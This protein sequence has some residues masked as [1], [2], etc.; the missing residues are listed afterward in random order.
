M[1][2]YKDYIYEVYKEKSISK[3]A[4]NL[5]VSQPSLSTRIIKIEKELGMP[6][7]DRSTSPLGLTEF[8]KIYIKAIEDIQEI[9]KRIQHTIEDL[10]MLHVGELTLGASN[11]FAA[12]ALPPIIAAFKKN[13][14]DVKIN[15]IEENTDTLEVLLNTNKVDMV[16]DNKQYDSDAYDRTLYTE[17]R[18]LL[19]VPKIFRECEQVKEFALNAACIQS[20][21][22]RDSTWPA[23]PLSVFQS[24]PFI[25]LT[26]NNDTRTRGNQI[27][28]EAGIQPNIVLEVHQQS[29]AY[30]IA[31]TMMGATFI[32]DS[33]VEKMPVHEHL[34]YYKIDSAA[35][36]RSVYF[37]YKK[38]KYKTRVMQEF[39]KF[40]RKK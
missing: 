6:I 11:I 29:T 3:A 19:A 2:R 15:L 25:M 27:C 38:N 24:V 34:A 9:E 1:F 37:Y 40:I 26:P 31:S 30:M 32:S 10:T 21:E 20:K 17:E 8:G 18:V 12:Y 35:A 7:F 33:I 22:Y 16:I 39:I 4:A 13:Y 14:P 5:Y 28:K 36:E 23:V